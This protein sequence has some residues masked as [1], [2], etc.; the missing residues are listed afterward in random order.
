MQHWQ[1]FADP[2]FK[3]R[4]HY[5]RTT[6]QGHSVETIESQHEDALRVHLASVGSQE[7]YFEVM[8]LCDLTPQ[9]EYQQHQ[10]DLAQ[11]FVGV[12]ISE[13]EETKLGSRPAYSYRFSW[14]DKERA[15]MLVQLDRA[16]YRIIYDP[17]S[18]LNAQVLSTVT[19]FE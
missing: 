11:R 9:Q 14:S 4:F 15:V 16:T 19:F 18:T 10:G 6:P 17:R 5:P 13:L 2:Q 1:L 3:L 7:L 8:K 12:T